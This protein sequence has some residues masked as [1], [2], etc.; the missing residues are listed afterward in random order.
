MTGRAAKEGNAAAHTV[1]RACRRDG[2]HRHDRRRDPG[3]RQQDQL[4]SP[5]T[6]RLR[7]L[8]PVLPA[9]AFAVVA[10]EV[11]QL[12]HQTSRATSEIGGTDPRGPGGD[13]RREGLHRRHGGILSTASTQFPRTS[14]PISSNRPRARP[15][16]PSNI[17]TASRV[18]TELEAAHQGGVLCRGR[19]LHRRERRTDRR[20]APYRRSAADLRQA[21]QRFVDKVRAA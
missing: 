4:C 7:R 13:R 14:P 5:S 12:A 19:N 21:M 2:A 6:P 9:K 11:K 15:T 16:L 1:Q 10:A 17:A 8:A 18:A 20:L 3:H